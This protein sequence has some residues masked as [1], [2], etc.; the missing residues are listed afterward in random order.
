VK[1]ITPFLL[2]ECFWNSFDAGT[3][4]EETPLFVGILDGIPLAEA[5]CQSFG[6][7]IEEAK[8]EITAAREE[9]QL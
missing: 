4:A 9:V 6:I 2:E 5:L 3:L 7:S 8:F 1:P